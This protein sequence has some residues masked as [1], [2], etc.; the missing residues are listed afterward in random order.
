MKSGGAAVYRVDYVRDK[1]GRITKK[2]ET[3]QGAARVYEYGYDLAGRLVSVKE[4]GVTVSTYDYDANGN[5]ITA[6]TKDGT[7]QGFYD[8]QDRM[9]KYGDASYTYTANGELLTKV[10][11]TWT[12]SYNYDVYGNLR[13]AT[14]PN[15]TQIDYVIDANNR[16][17]GKKLNG[18]LVQGF[19]YKDQLEPVAELDGSGNLVARFVYASKRHVP[20]YMIK[21]GV[22]YRIISD[23]LGS[24]RLMVNAADGSIAQRIDYDEFGNITSDTNY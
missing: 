4:N 8:L 19:I 7:F 14:M 2:T 10:E 21:G 5:R 24:V 1:I 16:R 13:A 11:P 22:T 18:A 20:D 17:I 15:G 23:H 9:T 6:V 3:I 12:T